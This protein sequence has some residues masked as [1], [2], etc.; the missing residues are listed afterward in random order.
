MVVELALE[1]GS[2]VTF[3][4]EAILM[5]GLTAGAGVA[6]GVG[7]IGGLM[8][9][10]HALLALPSDIPVT[11]P[12]RLLRTDQ[13]AAAVRGTFVALVTATSVGLAA[14]LNPMST[15][16]VLLGVGAGVVGGLGI[17]SSSAS[18]RL[19]ITQIWV[20][21]RGRLPWRLMTFLHDAHQRGALRQT[22]GVYEF[23]HHR[24][25]QRLASQHRISDTRPIAWP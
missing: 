25:Q 16:W 10:L 4:R 13:V 8:A 2:G 19:R 18:V 20:A 6:L 1:A 12:A 14:W 7:Q 5:A 24:L 15:M 23:R 22:G 11:S 17:A 3:T 9:G 21:S